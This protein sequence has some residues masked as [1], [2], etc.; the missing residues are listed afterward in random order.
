MLNPEITDT[1]RFD[2]FFR[3]MV[4][5][6]DSYLPAPF[7]MAMQRHFDSALPKDEDGE[8]DIAKATPD[9]WRAA[10]DHAIAHVSGVPA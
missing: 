4:E 10:I 8:T 5:S 7:S 6:L 2:A 1:Q 3:D 9:V